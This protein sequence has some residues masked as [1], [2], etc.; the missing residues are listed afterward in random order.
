LLSKLAEEWKITPDLDKPLS[1]LAS[2]GTPE[3]AAPEE[4]NI[5]ARLERAKND[6]TGA[7]ADSRKALVAAVNSRLESAIDAGDL[8]TVQSLQSLKSSLETGGSIPGDMKDPAVLAAN[9]RYARSIQSANT[10]LAEAY[11]D[12][13]RD[14]TRARKLSAAQ[15]TQAEFDATGL[16]ASSRPAGSSNDSAG[17]IYDLSAGLP[18]FLEAGPPYAI[19]KDGIRPDD[20]K[21]LRTKDADFIDRDFTFD[22][23]FVAEA[24]EN[25]GAWIGLGEGLRNGSMWRPTSSV[26]MHIEG[27]NHMNGAVTLHK[28]TENGEEIG[29]LPD[30]GTFMARLQKQGNAVTFAVGTDHNGTFRPDM[31]KRIDD[32]RGFAPFLNDHNTHVFFGSNFIFKKVRLLTRG[33]AAE[34]PASAA[35]VV[36]NFASLGMSDAHS[37]PPTAAPSISEIPASSATA[38]TVVESTA[39]LQPGLSAELF[40]DV[41]FEKLAASRVDASVSFDWKKGVKPAADVPAGY[42]SIRWKGV[43]EI[44]ASGI[45]GL[46]IAAD[47]GARLKIDGKD[48]F[49]FIKTSEKL[50]PG[51]FAPG[52]HTI[53][54]E[55]WNRGAAG[56]ARLLWVPAGQIE[57]QIVPASAL[58]HEP[59]APEK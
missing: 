23:W 35:P 57:P 27:I 42:F 4:A 3:N 39:A 24:R 50:V 47:D 44:P 59:P 36:V 32:I 16:A 31:S 54:I 48:Q 2:K 15:A 56:H 12:A 1:A 18:P 6:Y 5:A 29:K 11:R 19:E 30:T 8:R 55:Y 43:I 21:Y 14:Y 22:V 51:P 34:A 58:F 7:V 40:S 26:G 28:Q 25:I 53:E 33:G 10:T 37:A 45:L 13:V 49:E 38:P 20:K 46:G 52:R 17:N 41:K 9:A